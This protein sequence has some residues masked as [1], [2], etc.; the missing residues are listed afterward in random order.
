MAKKVS[1][2][3]V[4]LVAGL[5]LGKFFFR[6]EDLH[7]GYWPDDL[8]PAVDNLRA[9]Q[10]A[11]SRHL[12][13]QIPEGVQ[14]VLDVGSG[15]GKLAAALVDQG[16]SV[17]CVSPSEYLSGRIEERLGDRVGLYRC[18]FEKLETGQRYDLILFSESFQYVKIKAALQKSMEL[19]NDEGFILVCDFFRLESGKESIQAGGHDWAIFQARIKDIPVTNK[20]DIDITGRTAP[21]IQIWD[22]F[23]DEVGLPVRNL[24]VKYFQTQFPWITR[25]LGRVFRKRFARI[26]RDYFSGVSLHQDFLTH[27]SYRLLLYQKQ[28]AQPG[29]A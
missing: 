11:Y 13:E 5:A 21:T 1:S 20:L 25:L 9:A 29:P 19:L 3:E 12:I 15:G 14:K 27:K 18:K 22:A 6:A 10:E 26:D 23:L 24:M 16:Y 7:F 28:A 2:K 4:G 8:E 17:D